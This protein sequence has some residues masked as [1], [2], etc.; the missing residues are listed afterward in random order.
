MLFPLK[1]NTSRDEKKFQNSNLLK[2]IYIRIDT[3]KA[4]VEKNIY[5]LGPFSFIQ[6][7]KSQLI[8]HISSS[9]PS[10]ISNKLIISI[11]PFNA[12][13]LPYQKD[14]TGDRSPTKTSI[15]WNVAWKNDTN[16]YT[17]NIAKKN[18]TG[19]RVTNSN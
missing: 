9:F 3:K 16:I 12:L 17:L 13:Q 6:L 2:F 8:I 14:L 19:P 18:S 1:K 4:S 7:T 15:Q 11:N 5:N 10:G